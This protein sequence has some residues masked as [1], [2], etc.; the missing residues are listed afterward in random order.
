MR[1]S[2][3][4][5]AACLATTA[6]AAQTSGK[7]FQDDGGTN[8]SFGDG[9]VVPQGGECSKDNEQIYVVT[10]ES[11]L[12][13]FAPASLTFTKV[14]AINCSGTH[15]ATPFSMAVDRKGTAWV[16]FNDGHIYQVSTKDARC[17]STSYQPDQNNFHTFGMAFV[18]DTVGGST[19]T[20]YVADYDAKGL[21]K[22]DPA[23]LKLSFIAPY[24]GF[25]AP[26]ELT[27]RGDARMFAFFNKSATVSDVR[28]SEIDPKTA[29]ILTTHTLAGLDVGSGWAFA[30]W[31]GDFWLFTAPQGSSQVTKYSF[32][33]DTSTT[34][35]QNLGFVIVGAG[36][37][38]CAPFVPP[39]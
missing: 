7:G 10:R 6:C 17:T 26:G 5:V 25:S 15:A 4:L 19:E 18:S 16:L 29:K 14:G 27:G 34:V 32:D 28:V 13:Q 22:I 24:T 11:V 39:K 12:Y 36:V 1:R 9:G 8:I 30:H 35:K 21:A 2:L 38:T 37:S 33:G 20:L 23:Q 3:L 31:G